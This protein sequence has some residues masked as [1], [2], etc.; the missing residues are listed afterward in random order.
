MPRPVSHPRLSSEAQAFPIASK[1][2]FDLR[3][4]TLS[5]QAA[6][7]LDGKSTTRLAA[8]LE[9][10]LRPRAAGMS[11][12]LIRQIRDAAWFPPERLSIPLG[13]HLGLIAG[14]HL[15]YGGRRV[16]LR[17]DGDPTER[18]TCWRWLSLALP[19]DLL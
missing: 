1:T 18:A 4:T 13:E 3:L 12:E 9:D 10:H 7:V 15:E 11:L 17:A 14:R 6:G 8:A 5:R 2:A 19:A 16:I